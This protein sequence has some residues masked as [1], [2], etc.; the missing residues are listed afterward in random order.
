M[1]EGCYCERLI[2]TGNASKYKEGGDKQVS[3]TILYV[4]GRFKY[5]LLLSWEK[6][7]TVSSQTFFAKSTLL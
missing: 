3:G 2:T 5:I 4:L 7:E 1:L 6:Q